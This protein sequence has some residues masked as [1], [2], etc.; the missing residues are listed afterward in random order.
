MSQHK[1]EPVIL[2]SEQQVRQKKGGEASGSQ[3]DNNDNRKE[4]P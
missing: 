2:R 4:T 1:Y 3:R